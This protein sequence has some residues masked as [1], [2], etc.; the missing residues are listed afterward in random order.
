ME[1]NPVTGT[2]IVAMAMQL[3][4]CEYVYG[5]KADKNAPPNRIKAID[6]SGLVAYVVRRLGLRIP[7][8]AR[9]QY[10]FCKEISMDK[11]LKTP[12]ALLFWKRTG[13]GIVHVAISRG[14]GTT[15]E[16]RGKKFGVGVWSATKGRGFNK[17]ALIPGVKYYDGGIG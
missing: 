8:G 9:N 15:I 1:I 16:A 7:D 2:E 10:P 13:L 11:A 17:A 4:G 12:G 6:C 14:D 3:E 5:A